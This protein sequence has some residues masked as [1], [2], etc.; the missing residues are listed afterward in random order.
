MENE[1]FKEEF[2]ILKINNRGSPFILNTFDNIEKAKTELFTL[3]NQDEKRNKIYYIDNDFFENKYTVG[4]NAQKYYRI[5]KRKITEWE[6][7]KSAR[8]SNK[9]NNNKILI[10]EKKTI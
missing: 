3:I 7:Y 9:T 5:I 8:E 4:L 2:A 6:T 1:Q 10:F